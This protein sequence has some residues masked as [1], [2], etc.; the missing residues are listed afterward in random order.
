MLLIYMY[1][2][3]VAMISSLIVALIFLFL[4]SFQV[5]QSDHVG[6]FPNEDQLKMPYQTLE[7]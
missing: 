4:A 5:P 3:H 2:G 1:S 6:W 7:F